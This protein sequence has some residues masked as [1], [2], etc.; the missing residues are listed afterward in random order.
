MCGLVRPD[1]RLPRPAKLRAAT[2][3]NAVQATIRRDAY[4]G[5]MA[6]MR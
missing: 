5:A 4:D 3:R 2:D 1:G 6:A